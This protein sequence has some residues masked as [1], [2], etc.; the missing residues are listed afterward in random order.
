LLVVLTAGSGPRADE[1]MWTFDAP[2][3]ARLERDHGMAPTPEWLGHLQ[4]SS[5]RFSSGG[6]GSFIS[7]DGL[8]LTNHHVG[9]GALHKLGD[10]KHDY[11][12]DGFAATSREAELKCHDLELNVLESIE[13]VTARVQAA[14]KPGTTADEAF[15][16]R[17]AEERRRHAVPGGRLPPVPRQALHRR[18]AGL[19]ARASDRLL[20]RGRRQL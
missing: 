13:D 8:V 20:R 7:P 11:Y 1:G 9:A 10:E 5:V 19:R 16:A 17:R 2:P 6:S 15:A 3:R 14:V 4:R 12:R 18:A